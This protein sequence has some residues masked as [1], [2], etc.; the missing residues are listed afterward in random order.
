MKHAILSMQRVVNFGSVLQAWS[1]REM[2]RD[3]TGETADF[4]DIENTPALETLADN[5]EKQE[6][7][8]TAKM[9][10]SLLQRG[11][12]WCFT[13]LSTWNKRKIRTFMEKT[14]RLDQVQPDQRYDHVIIGS[15]EVFNHAC[16]VRLQLHGEVAQADRVLTYAASCG[17]ARSED[18]RREDLP[19]VREAMSRLQAVSVRDVGTA[20]YA[21]A[22]WDGQPLRHMDPVLMGPLQGRKIR[23]VW[24]KKYLLV[25]AYG[26]RIRTDAEIDAIR[27]FARAKGL[28]TVAVGG[29]Q[30]WC[31]L[32]IPASPM[33]ML[34]WFANA[35]YVVTDT[36]HG[37]IFSVIH[38]C[39]FA[40]IIRPSNRNKLT[41]LLE[42]LSLEKRSTAD[43]TRLAE[44][45]EAPVDY[46]A[47]DG[48]LTRE[49]QRA[50]DYLK[51]Q[52]C[53]V[54]GTHQAC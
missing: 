32:Y 25:Y 15:D 35:D 46:D 48:I 20:E 16:G 37:V 10:R 40:A 2:I 12:R 19:R 29:S 33:R 51:E 49:R 6:Y 34:D 42:D 7:G 13:R 4:I 39:R 24:L 53:D 54:Q 18:I 11:K 5:K 17:S 23:R 26:H 44:I 28:K 43:M 8:V 31:D 3:V 21:A 38:R 22:L 52:L 41:S 36:F 14:L 50:Q 9:S 47:V 30:F 1:L 45:L 27:S